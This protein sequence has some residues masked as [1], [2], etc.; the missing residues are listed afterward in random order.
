MANWSHL[1]S[2]H[3]AGP[4]QPDSDPLIASGRYFVPAFWIASCSEDDL[5]IWTDEDDEEMPYV[6][7]SIPKA[8]SQFDANRASLEA[9]SSDVS[10]YY[11]QWFDLLNAFEPEYLRMDLSEVIFMQDENDERFRKAVEFFDDVNQSNL[12]AFLSFSSFT[13]ILDETNR[14]KLTDYA[15]VAGQ[16]TELTASDY[17]VGMRD[18]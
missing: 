2:T 15:V 11:D 3:E 12:E 8:I 1:Y 18:V 6:S 9:I 13:D 17:L 14:G 7:L 5:G 4:P 16:S 10:L